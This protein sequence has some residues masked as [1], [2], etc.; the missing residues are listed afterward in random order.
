MKRIFTFMG[1]MACLISNA[2]N[3]D[4]VLRY[5]SENL[6]GTARFQAMGGA[7]GALGGDMSSLNINPAGSSVFNNNLLTVSATYFRQNTDSDYRGGLNSANS[8]T[9]DINQVGGALVFKTTDS[10]SK[11]KKFALAVNYDMVQNFD[12]L[13]ISGGIGTEGLDN[14]FLNFADGVPLQPL[15]LQQGETIG[16][17]YLDIGA[18]NGLGFVGQQAFLGFQ[19]G[20]ID[21]VID[22]DENTAYFSNAG[23]TDLA[24]D[25]RQTVSGYNSK[26]VVNASTQYGD[27][28]HFGASL[29]FHTIVYER[30]NQYREDYFTTDNDLRFASFDNLLRT[31]GTGFSMSVGAIAKL[32]QFIRLGG[33]YQSPTW[34]RLSD[35]YAQ[36]IDSN[37]PN[38]E[39]SFFFSELND[40]NLFD[41][42]IKTPSKLTGSIAAVFGANG[43]LSFDYSYQDMSNAELRPTSDAAF[44][45]ENIYISDVLRGVSSF[46]VGGEYRISRVS[47]RAGYRYKQSPYADNNIVGDIMGISGGVGLNFGSSKLDLAINRTEQDV[48]QY[49]FSTGINNPAVLTQVNTNFSLSY[50]LNF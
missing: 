25:F 35:A 20:I 48:L 15:K 11:W 47:L 7:F 6:Q 21:P 3:I 28:F 8:N 30:L 36:G 1:L 37:Y 12:D 10:G 9:L 29:N 26:F 44:A 19:A 2:Q 4:D 27:N 24:Q 5:S 50:T 31:D 18:T 32:N 38:K 16:S 39:E 41:Y 22:E 40:F 46:R 34:Y 13:N 49:F 14:Y 45:D 42:Q 23:Y 17:A 43:L 33:S